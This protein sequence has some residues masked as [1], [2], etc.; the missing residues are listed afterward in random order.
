MRKTFGAT[1]AK[2]IAVLAVVPALLLGALA[3]Y[4]L[5]RP[6]DPSFESVATACNL[7][8]GATT[9]SA[10]DDGHTLIVQSTSG[11]PGGTQA[12]ATSVVSQCVLDKLK[13]PASLRAKIDQTTALQGQTS[14]SWRSYELT[15][16]YSP[17]RGVEIIVQKP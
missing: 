6:H 14:D 13:A 4:L 7:E 5:S 17:D 1:P 10:E 9:I 16:S 12:I 8:Q 2:Q 11:D 3:W 15:W